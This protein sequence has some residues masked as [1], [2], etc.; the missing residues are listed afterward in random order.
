MAKPMRTWNTTSGRFLKVTVP[1][2]SSKACT[3]RLSYLFQGLI[4]VVSCIPAMVTLGR[5][6][7]A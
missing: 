4:R 6:R 1:A 7:L 5:L 3:Q 2:Q